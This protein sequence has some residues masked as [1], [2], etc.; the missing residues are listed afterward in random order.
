MGFPEWASWL[1]RSR[2]MQSNPV[3]LSHISFLFDQL[4]QIAFG[5]RVP[6]GTEEVEHKYAPSNRQFY[7]LAY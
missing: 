6:I 7:G 2:S 5:V 1:P 4:D 3:R